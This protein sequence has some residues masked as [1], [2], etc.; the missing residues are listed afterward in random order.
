MPNK[1]KTGKYIVV[2]RNGI[3]C[4][5]EKDELQLHNLKMNLR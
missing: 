1:K 2:I 5:S 4:S 3:L